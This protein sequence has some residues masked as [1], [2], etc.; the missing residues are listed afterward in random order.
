MPLHRPVMPVEA[1][2]ALDAEQGGLFVD[3]TLGLGGHTELIL[4]ASAKPFAN[5]GM[6]W[7]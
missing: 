4:R 6:T 1:L 5:A 2:E 3:A 7:S